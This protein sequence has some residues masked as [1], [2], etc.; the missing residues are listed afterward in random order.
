M[1]KNMESLKEDL[2][3]IRHS[4]KCR[5]IKYTQYKGKEGEAEAA[6]RALAEINKLCIKHGIEQ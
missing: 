3:K 6:K 1:S 4:F 5:H 2:K